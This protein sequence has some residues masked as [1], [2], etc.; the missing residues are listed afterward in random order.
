MGMKA[1]ILASRSISRVWNGLRCVKRLERCPAAVSLLL[2]FLSPGGLVQLPTPTPASI[3]DSLSLWGSFCKQLPLP[4]PPC[5]PP[6]APA[7]AAMGT[8]QEKLDAWS[9]SVGAT[10]EAGERVLG[11]QACRWLEP[12]P[13]P[14]STW[15]PASACQ[16]GLPAS[17]SWQEFLSRLSR[18]S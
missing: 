13:P 14:L 5:P 18:Q 4:L 7:A 8:T 16:T 2:L 1:V 12:G 3:A 17:G 10:G 6:S 11:E 15:T 9:S